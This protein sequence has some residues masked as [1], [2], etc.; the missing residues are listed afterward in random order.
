MEEKLIK[1]PKIQGN[2]SIGLHEPAKALF[3]PGEI[4]VVLEWQVKR[5][6]GRVREQ[7]IK[8][9]ESYVRQFLDLLLVQMLGITEVSPLP[10]VDTLGVEKDIAQSSLNFECAAAANIDSYG[11]VVGTG[12]TPPS[13]HDYALENQ[14]AHGAEPGQLQ[15]GGVAFGLPTSNL[16][17]SHFTV[18]RDLANASGE[19]IVV[20][21]IGLYVK[22][23]MPVLQPGTTN[24]GNDSYR[25][26]VSYFCTIR[27]VILHGISV[28]N[29]ETLTVNYRQ[30]C[31][32]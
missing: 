15:Y 22:G 6:D 3:Q 19:T 14:I 28:L 13:I 26:T 24:R 12:S 4:G 23:D 29:G 21:E 31:V 32:I 10:I 18:T 16:T 9:G 25:P 11:I 8:K 27:D 2:G 30:Q 20:Y 5:P 17:A 7:R 1:L